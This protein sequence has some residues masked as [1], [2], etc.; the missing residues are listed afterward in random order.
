M[1]QVILVGRL[2]QDPE[3]E[4]TETGKKITIII[5]AV[6]RGFKNSEGKYETDCRCW[7]Y[8]GADFTGQ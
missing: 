3:Y 5:I 1:N 8:N 4:I 6:T 2:S 7:I